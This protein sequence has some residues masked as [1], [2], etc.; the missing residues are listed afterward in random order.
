MNIM[1]CCNHKPVMVVDFGF[2]Y[3]NIVFLINGTQKWVVYNGK[4]I[5][6]LMIWVWGYHGYPYFW[7]PSYIDVFV[8]LDVYIYKNSS[9]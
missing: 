2:A 9:S 5:Y 1:C 6:K 7:K 4:S 3:S 8:I